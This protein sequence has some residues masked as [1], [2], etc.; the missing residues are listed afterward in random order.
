[1]RAP[2]SRQTLTS[3]KAFKKRLED[4]PINSSKLFPR[5]KASPKRYTK[6]YLLQATNRLQN[7]IFLLVQ[8]FINFPTTA[9]AQAT[10][11]TGCAF[12]TEMVAGVDE[13]PVFKI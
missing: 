10:P 5:R 9:P 12:C 2:N 13:C 7:K 3:Q 6:A 4:D 8:H 1:M 11:T